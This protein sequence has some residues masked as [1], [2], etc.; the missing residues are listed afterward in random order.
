VSAIE[1]AY[2][3]LS[4][5]NPANFEELGLM[6]TITEDPFR[7]SRYSEPPTQPPSDATMRI[8]DR[9]AVH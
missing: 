7:L 5:F 8:V 1:T 6:N 4:P 2:Y 9:L 3:R